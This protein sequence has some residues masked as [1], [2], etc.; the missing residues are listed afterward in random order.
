MMPSTAVSTMALSRTAASRTASSACFRSVMSRAILVKPRRLVFLVEDRGDHAAGEEA[1]AVLALV[2]A[3]V[4]RAALGGGGGDLSLGH[5]AGAVLG[6]EEDVELL[7]EDLGLGVAEELLGAGV[8]ADDPPLGVDR[9]NGEILDA[10][11]HEPQIFLGLAQRLLDTFALGDLVLEL[12]PPRFVLAR[13]DPRL[14][15]LALGADLIEHAGDDRLEVVEEI[16][17]LGHEV[18]HAGAQGLD[19][20]VLVLAG[21]SP[22]WPARCGRRP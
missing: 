19:Q 3:L 16:G 11:D 9:E 18:A 13:D 14:G 12:A 4:G 5:A 20:Q 21:R 2:P 6:G 7:A 22:G 8:P 17:G 1:A 10:L 15:Q